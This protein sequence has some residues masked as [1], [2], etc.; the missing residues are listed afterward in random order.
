MYHFV[1]TTG[2]AERAF[3][4][5]ADVLGIELERSMF[6]GPAPPGAP[7]ERIRSVAEAGSDPLVW[8]L[9]DTHG[10]RFRTAFMR[11]PNAPFGLELSE[12]FDIPRNERAAQPWDP[13]A[14]MLM[15][16]VRDLAMITARLGRIGA[17]IVT[18]GG[19][20]VDTRDGRALL[21]RDPDGSL[22]LLRQASPAEIAVAAEPGAIVGLSIGITV[23]DLPRALSFYRDLLGFEVGTTQ[24]ATAAELRVQGLDAGTLMRTPI[25]IPDTDIE[26]TLST[27]EL[28]P[29]ASA[30][31]FRWRIQ[32][33]GAPQLQLE[34]AG[35]DTLL[36]RTR[37]SGYRFLSVGGEPIQ[38]PF[39][40]FVF[41]IDADGVLVE[42]VEPAVQRGVE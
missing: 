40:R 4:F 39:G 19:T 29:T 21:V 30:T 26:V 7:P 14:S 20:P 42:Y 3:A 41:A 27:F 1:R 28:A 35:L 37:R 38:R 11:A 34:V 13:G 6:A 22:V 18:L 31:P 16:D 2:D 10:A 12:F 24:R 25:S 9:T 23:A 17:P 36:E 33:V 32:D 8:N 15:F 5:Y